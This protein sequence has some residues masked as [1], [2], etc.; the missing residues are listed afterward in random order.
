MHSS[1]TSSLASD[2]ETRDIGVNL[3]ITDMCNKM[4]AARQMQSTLRLLLRLVLIP[5]PANSPFTPSASGANPPPMAV[6]LRPL[7]IPEIFYRLAGRAAVRIEGPLVGPTMAPVEHGDCIPFGCQIGAKGALCALDARKALSTWAGRQQRLYL[8]R[9]RAKIP[10]RASL[11]ASYSI[12]YGATLWTA[13][14]PTVARSVG[15][16]E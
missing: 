8:I 16:M 14:A 9:S 5:K 1:A 10:F 7:G 11:I 15:G 6:T 3:L 4:L 13:N 12:M 2:T